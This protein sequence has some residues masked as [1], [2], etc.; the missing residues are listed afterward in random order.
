MEC[1][2]EVQQ[3]IGAEV[4]AETEIADQRGERG[5]HEPDQKFSRLH[6]GPIDRE[7]AGGIIIPQ[8]QRGFA[9]AARA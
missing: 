8:R 1:V 4:P 2:R 7:I 9:D 6:H 3:E 5:E